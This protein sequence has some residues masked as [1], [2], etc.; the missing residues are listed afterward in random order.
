MNKMQAR[1][2]PS[3]AVCAS[4]SIQPCKDLLH[5]FIIIVLLL[6]FL[7]FKWI[8]FGLGRERRRGRIKLHKHAIAPKVNVLT[9]NF[10]W[11]STVTRYEHS[12]GD[13]CSLQMLLFWWNWASK[14]SFVQCCKLETCRLFSMKL[15]GWAVIFKTWIN[16]QWQNFDFSLLIK[17]FWWLLVWKLFVWIFLW[18]VV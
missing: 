18:K 2:D 13:E 17:L 1:A 11:L 4:H 3:T 12:R 9:H 15:S 14:T 10:R 8:C 7:L 16:N 6:R 5:S